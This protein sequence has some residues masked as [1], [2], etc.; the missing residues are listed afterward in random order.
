MTNPLISVVLA[1]HNRAKLLQKSIASI[2]A[3]TLQ[4]FEII[5]IDDF[6]Q[7]ETPDIIKALCLSD[8]RITSLRTGKNIGPGSARNLGIQKARGDLIAIMDDDDLSLPE[9]LKI[10]SSILR[11]H[12]EVGLVFS[13]VRWIDDKGGEILRF[14]GITIRGEFPEDPKE[15][16]R[17]LYL[18]SNKIP[19]V[20]VMARK[21]IFLSFHYPSE[22]W[23]GEDWFLG[24]L[25]SASGI[26]FYAIADCLVDILRESDH[27]SLMTRTTYAHK[28]QRIVLKSIRNWLKEQN[29]HSF[30]SLHSKAN[31]NQIVREARCWPG[32]HG[33]Y[34]DLWAICLYPGNL[35]AWRT[36]YWF[37]SKGVSKGKRIIGLN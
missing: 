18:E 17:L 1:T 30:D 28:A 24:M 9:R 22:P 26:R 20:T 2:Q 4:D 14:P 33:L 15:V 12:P 29:I 13:A 37:L 19:N 21:E 7:D 35:Y 25:L 5:I 34:L 3:Q 10:Q 8:D 16:F 23:V 36:L 31:S 27:P 11:T 6:S 32:F